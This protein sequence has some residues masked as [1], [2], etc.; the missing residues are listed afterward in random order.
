MHR[1]DGRLAVYA[2]GALIGGIVMFINGFRLWRKRRL[3]ENTPQ[4]RI[5]SMAMGLVEL[6]G[7][8][9]P[10]SVLS[11][12]FS[13]SDCAYWQVDI[14]EPCKH[15]WS[16]IHKNSSRHPFYL[17]DQTGVAL[18]YPDGSECKLTPGVEEVC[19]KKQIPERFAAYIRSEEL[20]NL[21]LLSGGTLRFR[22][23]VMQNGQR[24]FIL[25]SAMP[26][27]N[28]TNI[29]DDEVMQ[30]TGT[31]G[32]AHRIAD[33]DRQLAAVIR[34]GEHERTF[35]IS[36]QSESELASGLRSQALVQ[37]VGGPLLSLLGLGCWLLLLTAWGVY[38]P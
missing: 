11:A 36:E 13:G 16:V 28:A 22:E 18:V 33:L 29:S 20:K 34:R 12:P 17:R 37:L 19:S 15:G 10:R 9:E 8:V 32:P 1:S 25:G 14:S 3:I 21:G 27:P 5:R 7:A 30:A 6:E 31:D 38:H 26:R 35:V 23:R 4:A 24:A 2:T